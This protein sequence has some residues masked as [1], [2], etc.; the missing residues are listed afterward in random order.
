MNKLLQTVQ[1]LRAKV[2]GFRKHSL[3][4]T[5][6]R[7]IIIDPFL[8]ALGWDVRDPDE[9]QL[10]YP[11]VDGKSVDYALQINGKPV[12]FV[13]AK[14][15]DDP[16]NDVK[17][18]TQV[19]GYA[20]NAGVVWCVLT[21]GLKW[22]VY[23]SVEKCS[24][25]DKLMFEVSLDPRDSDGLS[26]Q[27]ISQKLWQFSREEMARGTLDA[28]GEQTFTDGKVRKALDAIM[29]AAPRPFLNMVKKEA[30][31]DQL[32]P[33]QIKESIARIWAADRGEIAAIPSTAAVSSSEVDT[34]ISGRSQG[35][36]KAW[37]ARKGGSAYHES[38]HTAGKPQEVLE[39]YRAVDRLSLSLKP[40]EI[41]KDC[42]AKYISYR[43]GKAIF[44]N[45]HIQQGRLRVWLKLKYSRLDNPPTFARDV[46]N[47]GH[48]GT[49]DLEL[50]ISDLSQ[51][52]EAAMLIR[53]SF[54]AR[55]R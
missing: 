44:C 46:S 43:C 28:L 33:R 40:G 5:P 4:E 19:V 37:I 42:H 24:A 52:D 10:E 41:E 36:K 29:R 50:A 12:L 53:K 17:A 27:Q 2:D 16:L 39:L 18:I 31:D 21:N 49:G 11:T 45:V 35:A 6:T 13:E 1:T 9:V 3:K 7:T 15:I 54:E 25:P 26:V 48:W 32:S 47:V 8:E 55:G 20:A 22:K 14:A 34:G 38:H 51:L 23:R 30:G